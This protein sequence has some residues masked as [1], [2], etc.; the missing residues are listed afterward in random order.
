MTITYVTNFIGDFSLANG[1]YIVQ[2][3][4]SVDV[5]VVPQGTE[6]QFREMVVQFLT[7]ASQAKQSEHDQ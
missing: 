2:F 4:S 1:I 5:E 6:Q 3:Y 7:A